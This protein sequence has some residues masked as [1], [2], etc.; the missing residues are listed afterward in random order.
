MQG[1][2]NHFI[3]NSIVECNLKNSISENDTVIVMWTNVCRK[4]SYKNKKWILPGNHFTI[5]DSSDIRGYYLRDL[6]FIYA[7]K[8]ILDQTGCRYYFTSMVPISNIDQHESIDVS[9]DI[10]DIINFYS[11]TLNIIRTSVYESVFKCN[12]KNRKLYVDKQGFF[13]YHPTPLLHLE[14]VQKVL[15]EFNV[16]SET[17]NWIKGIDE[18]ILSNGKYDWPVP[19]IKRW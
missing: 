11:D 14:Y 15:P 17:A 2:S 16:K 13:D 5:N 18:L 8:K 19:K 6:A 4:D 9:E 1:A 12:W 3:F 7:T 10:H